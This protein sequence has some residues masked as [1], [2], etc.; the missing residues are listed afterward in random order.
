MN[1]IESA[2]ACFEDGFNCAQAIF[3]TYGVKFGLEREI[4][5]KTA[6]GFGGGIGAMGKTC[7]A[8]TGA[9]LVLGLKFGQTTLE[10]TQAK[11][12]TFSLVIKLM[13]KFEELNRSTTCKELIGCDL[14]T[15]E[16]Q[17][18][19]KEK[20]IVKTICPKFVKDAAEILEQFI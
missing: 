3:S 5:L 14:S 12:K 17:K 7:G 16:G 20:N 6:T 15:L 19:A 4:A 13:K 1:Y 8:I 9:I 11:M 18:L 10:D 2:V